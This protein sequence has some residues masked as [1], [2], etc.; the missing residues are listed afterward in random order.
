MSRPAG[1]LDRTKREA[2]LEAG[3]QCLLAEGYGASMERIATVA[4]VSKQTVYS[5]FGS[6]EELVRAIVTERATAI[7]EPLTDLTEAR[8][9]AATLH[10]F[11]T[12]L[13]T[14]LLSQPVI[15]LYRLVQSRAS[16]Q[17]EL[18]RAY[19]ESGPRTSTGRLAAYLDRAMAEGALA[20]DDAQ[21]AAEMFVGLLL[22]QIHLKATL[23]LEVATPVEIEQRVATAVRIFL[24]AYAR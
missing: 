7:T 14:V 15:G 17:P 3:R 11:G 21:I 22:S 20:A 13:L 6:K 4:G 1:T 16:E 18:A 19:F 8:L 2:I 9:P 23:G 12:R 5:H 10:A 24:K